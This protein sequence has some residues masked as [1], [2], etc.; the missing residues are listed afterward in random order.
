[1][2]DCD[3]FVVLYAGRIGREKGV[4]VLVKAFGSSQSRA[5]RVCARRRGFCFSWGRPRGLR[6]VRGRAAHHGGRVCRCRGSRP[7]ASRGA[8][9][10][11]RR[12]GGPEPVA[13]AA[14]AIGDGAARLRRSRW[15]RHGWAA[16]PRSSPDWLAGFL[17]EPGD[18]DALAGRSGR[19][20]AGGAAA[21]PISGQRCRHEAEERLLAR[22]RGRRH[23]ASPHQGD[24]GTG[25][26]RR[27][28]TDS[29][30][31]ARS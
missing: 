14:V 23:R 18:D 15:W 31:D 1:M 25:A 20:S 27:R 11:S 13:R 5:R 12:R 26:R 16:T 9:P 8:H 21:S 22:H 10:G 6:T 2:G 24:R 7:G 19:R 28:R 3:S 29:G 4:D 17:V 30:S